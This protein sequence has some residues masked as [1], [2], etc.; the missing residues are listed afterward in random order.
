MTAS[1]WL[2]QITPRNRGLVALFCGLQVG[3]LVLPVPFVGQA[4]IALVV[5]GVLSLFV[6]TSSVYRATLFLAFHARH[7]FYL[8]I[9]LTDF[10]L[11]VVTA[12]LWRR[13]AREESS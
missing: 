1:P 7:A 8:A 11:F 13:A 12:L 2:D 4:G 3:L 5:L 6:V 9:F 10:P